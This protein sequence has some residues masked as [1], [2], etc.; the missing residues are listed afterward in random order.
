MGEILT[1]ANNA[2]AIEVRQRLAE[3]GVASELEP[4]IDLAVA[5]HGGHAGLDG[6]PL[7]LHC[8]DVALSPELRTL[9]QRQLG[10]LHDAATPDYSNFTQEEFTEQ[11]RA[12]GCSG[13]VI[14]AATCFARPQEGWLYDDW[15]SFLMRDNL[16]R[17]VKKADSDAAIRNFPPAS[18]TQLAAWVR[19]SQRLAENKP[20]DPETTGRIEASMKVHPLPDIRAMTTDHNE[21]QP[22]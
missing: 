13:R 1:E 19:T 2:T 22:S 15:I 6:R 7:A 8:A 20:E 21:A 9:E 3:L 11:A 12:M 18:E 16:T 5:A 10:L 14:A 4:A 17:L